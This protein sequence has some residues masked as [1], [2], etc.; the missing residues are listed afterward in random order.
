MASNDDAPVGANGNG[1]AA[2][3]SLNVL[4]QY[5]KDLSFESPGAPNSLRGR[6][7]APGIA[8]NVNVNANP[9]SDKQFDVNLTLNAKASFDQEVLFNVELV[10]GGVFAISGFPQEHMLPILFIECPRLLFPFARQIIAEATRNG[11]FPPL[12]LDPIDFAQMF[13]Q[14]LAEDQAASSKTQVS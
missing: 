5:V 2:Q 6:D 8:I 14:K 11:G 13:Q 3:P 12:M 10:Y 1:N 9:L 7:K 4:A